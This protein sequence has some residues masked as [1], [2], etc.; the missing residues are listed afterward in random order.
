MCGCCCCWHGQHPPDTATV[1][2]QPYC[3]VHSGQLFDPMIV[4]LLAFGWLIILLMIAPQNK[5]WEIWYDMASHLKRWYISIVNHASV[6]STKSSVVHF[7]FDE[8]KKYKVSNKLRWNWKVHKA[9]L[10]W[11]VLSVLEFLFG[12]NSIQLWFTVKSWVLTGLV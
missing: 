2:W 4:E 5:K 7:V 1:Q 12:L 8:K 3:K 6:K 9:G 11:P 10:R